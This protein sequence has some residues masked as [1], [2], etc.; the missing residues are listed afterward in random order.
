MEEIILGDFNIKSP[1]WGSPVSD[2]R[3]EFFTEWFDA[4]DLVVHN[5]GN[6]PTFVMGMS[7]SFIDVTCSTQKIAK[8]ILNWKVLDDEPVSDHSFIYFEIK[9][10]KVNRKKRDGPQMVFFDREKFQTELKDKA[11]S[12]VFKKRTSVP[13]FIEVLSQL[14]RRSCMIR[15]GRKKLKVPYW[16]N[17]G[18]ENIRRNCISIRRKIT[19]SKRRMGLND[20]VIKLIK[21]YK[22][23]RTDLKKAINRAKLQNWKTLCDELNENPWGNGFKIVMKHL[24]GP[25][26]PYNLSKERKK[27]IVCALFPHKE[28]QWKRGNR[29]KKVATF[30]ENELALAG[31]RM[32]V[33]KAPGP[34]N[35]PSDVVKL[36]IKAAPK[37][38]LEVMNELLRKQY[39]PER[40]KTARVCLIWKWGKPLEEVTSFRPICLLDTMGKLLEFMLR[41]RL[42]K[43]IE[44]KGNLSNDQYGF[45]KGR[46]TVHAVQTIINVVEGSEEKW[47]ALVTLD[48][49]NAFNT[50]TWSCVI[51]ELAVRGISRYLI[52]MIESYFEHRKISIAGMQRD[53]TVGVPQGSVLGPT[54]W[55][56]MYD[57]LVREDLGE[58]IKTIAY[59][60]DLA[61]LV[62]DDEPEFLVLKTNEALR[63]IDRWLKMHYL[64]LAPEKTEAVILKGKRNWGNIEFKIK[65]TTITPSKSIKYLGIILGNF[66]KFG[67]HIN[68]VT[69]TAEEKTA[70]L[71]RLM[72]NIGGPLSEKRKVLSG[73]M[74]SILLY[75]CPV[76]H[77]V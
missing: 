29:V 22:E 67:N 8:E 26:M 28:D 5:T 68:T 48:I 14:Y 65:N 18:I 32:K 72:P 51:K 69:N 62:R 12:F 55:N 70:A 35:I 9:D 74:H 19:R 71:S 60:D 45:R 37:L 77:R 10:R 53:M 40:W 21:D 50:A 52:N 41:E 34:D 57:G 25:S 63:R 73:V 49:R 1:R 54:L 42:E 43:E 16:W 33:G 15:D 38:V 75:G 13:H 61:I 17:E 46:S 4:L 59:A 30:T 44:E 76:W 20:E 47:C 7:A 6:V 24:K 31:N 3:G 11:R 64:E 23:T 39:F 36:A 56:I 2:N 58:H 27:E 66:L